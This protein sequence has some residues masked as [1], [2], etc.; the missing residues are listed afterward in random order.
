MDLYRRLDRAWARGEAALTVSLLLAMVSIASLSAG[1]RNLTRFDVAWA[2][3]LLNDMEW[4]DSFLRNATVLLAFLGA[5]QATYYR[6]HIHIDAITRVLSLRARYLV[7]AVGSAAASLIM[8]ALAASLGAAV[9]LHSQER[10]IEYEILGDHGSM[11]V[12]D[13]S[14]QQLEQLEGLQRPNGFCATRWLAK[15]IGVHSET[16]GALSLLVVP[17]LFAGMG[18]RFLA[19]SVV[20]ARAVLR[21]EASLAELET[22]ERARLAAVHASLQREEGHEP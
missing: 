18:L 2:N 8:F 9:E 15:R 10:P 12:C 1:I 6:K 16:P 13:A 14:A 11:H 17:L 3:A 7:H 21:G 5:S 20:S 22:E 4:A 19:I